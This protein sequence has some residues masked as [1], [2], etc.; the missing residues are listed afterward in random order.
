MS[1][2]LKRNLS[3]IKPKPKPGLSAAVD[4]PSGWSEYN[5]QCYKYYSTLKSATAAEDY[6]QSVGGHLVT[7]RNENEQTFVSSLVQDS[8]SSIWIGFWQIDDGCWRWIE[9]PLDDDSYC[10]YGNTYSNGPINDAWT[11]WNTNEPNDSG[12][13]DCAHL[14]PATTVGHRWNDLDCSNAFPFLCKTGILRSGSPSLMR[15]KKGQFQP[16]VSTSSELDSSDNEEIVV[17]DDRPTSRPGSLKLK[18]SFNGKDTTTTQESSQ[19]NYTTTQS[20]PSDSGDDLMPSDRGPPPPYPGVIV[21]PNK[22]GSIDDLLQ[23]SQYEL[24]SA[25]PANF[26]I[27]EIEEEL[28]NQPASPSTHDAIQGMLSMSLPKTVP[29]SS[30]PVPHSTA[31]SSF[32]NIPP[33]KPKRIYADLEDSPD[34]LPTCFQDS[35]YVPGCACPTTA[36]T[37]Y[38]GSCYRYFGQEM[39]HTAAET[40]C[41]NNYNSHLVSITSLNEQRFVSSLITSDDVRVWIGLWQSTNSD[42]Y[43]WRDNPSYCVY[44]NVYSS[45]TSYSQYTYWA[46][47]QPDDSGSAEHCVHFFDRTDYSHLWNDNVCST[48][49]GFVCE[50]GF[51]GACPTVDQSWHEHD[52]RLYRYFTSIASASSA[53]TSCNDV[54]NYNG[55]LVSITSDSEQSFVTGLITDDS[56]HVW[57]GLWQTSNSDCYRWRDDP[58]YCVS[59]NVDTGTSYGQYTRWLSYQPDDASSKEHCVHLYDKESG[60]HYWNDAP[61]SISYAYVCETGQF[62]SVAS[63]SSPSIGENS[64]VGSVV[65]TLT[66]SDDTGVST[67][68]LLSVSEDI[69][70]LEKTGSLTATIKTTRALDYEAGDR[71]FTL[72]FQ[73]TDTM[74]MCSTNWV[75]FNVA[76]ENDPVNVLSSDGDAYIDENTG[77][78]YYVYT[79]CMYDQDGTTGD[80]MSYSFTSVPSGGTALFDV[81]SASLSN[82]DC[83]AYPTTTH[84]AKVTTAANVNHEVSSQYGLTITVTDSGGATDTHA[85]TVHVGDVN[86]AI[87]ITDATTSTL[88]Y[89]IPEDTAGLTEL[90]T[91][92]YFDEDGDVP[93]FSLVTVNGASSYN[94]EIIDEDVGTVRVTDPANFD[95][96]RGERQY[97]LKITCT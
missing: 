90:F 39:S 5:D 55:H 56:A 28:K 11:Y 32:M 91:V 14:W 97:L 70:I 59:D 67:F 88:R 7:V 35:K 57:M 53:E 62:P 50:T 33:S 36:W 63:S 79:L 27:A 46:H 78:N 9:D 93:T 54:I 19:E 95:W 4:C 71:T 60:G 48:D 18:L 12:G 58:T 6:C 81:A 21:V 1:D 74:G 76:N 25:P 72:H 40:T 13:E 30:S 23:A 68:E 64:A 22:V 86:D 83:S 26:T 66:A 47:N 3:P 61:R 17:D 16:L 87:L 80:T 73:L 20:E 29:D 45:S 37:E 8:S 92:Q 84:A 42:C 85:V 34:S 31:L 89:S 82:V 52:G 24:P 2:L 75:T 77:A 41:Q 96:D 10:Q 65:Y 15:Q 44:P 69:F 43:R 38:D 94:F 49:Y 51:L